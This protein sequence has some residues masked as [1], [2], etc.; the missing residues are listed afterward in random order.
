MKLD[1]FIIGF[2]NKY[3]D[4]IFK[5]DEKSRHSFSS[6][7]DRNEC[8]M[9]SW[10]DNCNSNVKTIESFLFGTT[11]ILNL[12]DFLLYYQKLNPEAIGYWIKISKKGGMDSGFFFPIPITKESL[13]SLNNENMFSQFIQ[14]M[15]VNN[16]N[17]INY[18]GSDVGCPSCNIEIRLKLK[19]QAVEEQLNTAILAFNYFN[20]PDIPINILNIL[21]QFT[22]PGLILSFILSQSS[23]IKIG[24]LF[25]NPCDDALSLLEK[26]MGEID[27]TLGSPDFIELQYLKK[28]Y[29]HNLYKE[30]YN[31]Y[32]HFY[33]NQ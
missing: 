10:G 4:H 16:I 33:D 1:I 21:R 3:F 29:T 24:I 17:E 27:T 5:M 23:C 13:K 30:G 28:E 14:W 20:I 26:E 9:S 12:D 8:I 31:I 25:P 11:A 22:K 15:E 2:C 32:F 19:E 7:Y 18:F 6:S